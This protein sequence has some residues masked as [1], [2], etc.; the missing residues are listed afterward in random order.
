MS[1]LNTQHVSAAITRLPN[2]DITDIFTVTQPASGR[3]DAF[4]QGDPYS[5]TVGIRL[6]LTDVPVTLTNANEYGS[7]AVL[8]LAAATGALHFIGPATADLDVVCTG[9][10]S[11]TANNLTVAIGTAAA[12]NV[13]LT[14]TMVN[15]CAL[16][17]YAAL[18]AGAGSQRIY[19]TANLTVQGSAVQLFLNYALT[20]GTSISS[21]GLVTVSG[22]IV[23]RLQS[24]VANN[25][26]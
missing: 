3:I 5:P 7:V 14:S 9:G 1:Q 16:G 6:R 15:V 10:I 25:D 20:G 2:S 19:S 18:V 22:E 8:N 12:S 17:T 26:T 4:R 13:S 21:D 23:I 24:V 11:A